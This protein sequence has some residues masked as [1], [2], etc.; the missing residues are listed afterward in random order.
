MTL[1]PSISAIG[2]ALARAQSQVKTPRA[3]A[4]DDKGDRYADF[5]SIMRAAKKPLADNELTL[6]MFGGFSSLTVL[7][8]HNPTSEYICETT[9]VAGDGAY[10][11]RNAVMRLLGMVEKTTTT[12]PV[13]SLDDIEAM[14][15]ALYNQLASLGLSLAQIR[16]LV[17]KN[18]DNYS[19]I[20]EAGKVLARG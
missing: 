9:P 15:A 14:P 13:S 10:G 20:L 2:K 19:A 12:V 6:A 18:G 8:I 7:L 16:V 4:T 11:P 1:S 5:A 3:N 17:N